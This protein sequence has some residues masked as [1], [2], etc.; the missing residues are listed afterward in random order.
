MPNEFE[1]IIIGAGQA[2]LSVSYRLNLEGRNHV[3]LEQAAQAANAWRNHRWESFTLNTPNWQSQLPG[4]HMPGKDPDAFSTRQEIITYFENY[5]RENRL[6]VWYKIRVLAVRAAGAGFIVETTA[7]TFRATNVVVA[8]GLYQRP[9]MPRFDGALSSAI[10]QLH[11]D[12]YWKPSHLA[13]GA[14]LV[15]GSGQSGAQIAEELYLSGRK[16]YL[17]V[18]RAGRVPRRYRGKDL[19]WWSNALGMYERSVDQLG[20]PREKFA[21]KPHISGTMGGHTLNL[22]QFAI[23][24]VT[25]LGRVTELNESKVSLARDLHKNLALADQFESN[26]LARIDGFIKGQGLTFPEETLAHLSA[27]FLQPE[28]DNLDLRRANISSVIW[29]TG[30]SFD[31]GMVQFP[32]FDADGYPVQKRGVTDYVGLYFTGLPW[33]HNAKSGLLFGTAEE[34]AYIVSHIVDRNRSEFPIWST[35]VAQELT[36]EI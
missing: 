3:V 27:G 11:S 32:I 28:R 14:V 26:F 33:L 16:V 6:P 7:G 22:H 30:Y 19:N 20:S 31:F 34:S 24:G 12:A 2:G 4:A 25:L 18:S 35:S 23:D 10:V 13:E 5:I 29:A 9:Q 1:T 21:G 8:T 15:V 36:Y 17:S